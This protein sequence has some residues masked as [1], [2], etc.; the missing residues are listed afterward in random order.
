MVGTFVHA[1]PCAH[2]GTTGG[3]VKTPQ[4]EARSRSSVTQTGLRCTGHLLMR[5]VVNATLMKDATLIEHLA[6]VQ[7]RTPGLSCCRKRERRRRSGRPRARSVR[8]PFLPAPLRTGRATF[9]ASGS[10]VPVLR[11]VK[12]LGITP[13]RTP[14]LQGSLLPFAMG[15]EAPCGRL[16]RPQTTT[17][18]P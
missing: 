15:L 18:A 6:E 3:P 17:E 16:S 12:A 13:T 7:G 5:M 4:A 1:L 11:K 9:T 10:P 8:P 2:T 14:S